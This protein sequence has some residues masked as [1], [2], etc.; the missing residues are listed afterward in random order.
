MVVCTYMMSALTRTFVPVARIWLVDGV[1]LL[2]H[3]LHFLIVS[4]FHELQRQL[5]R[6][7]RQNVKIRA[8]IC[9]NYKRV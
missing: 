1:H 7:W 4:G 6:T 3:M 8:V 5:W 9:I 2:M